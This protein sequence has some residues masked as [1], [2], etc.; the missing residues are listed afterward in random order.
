MTTLS[1]IAKHGLVFGLAGLSGAGKTTLAEQ[2]IASIVRRGQSIASIKH[3]HHEFDPDQ[4]GK[5]SWRHRKA[6]ASEMI[7][8]SANR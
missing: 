7:I 3:A 5:D 8:S 2:L 4:P 6:G 1:N